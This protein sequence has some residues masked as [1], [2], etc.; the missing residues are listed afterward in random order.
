MRGFSDPHSIWTLSGVALRI[1]QRIGLH[2]DG[3]AFGLTAFETEMRRRIWFQL[4]LIDAT[5]AQFCG[6]APSPSI[7][8]A[9]TQPP[10]NAN[11]SDLDPRMTEPVPERSGATE[12]IFCLTRSEFGNWLRRWGKKYGNFDSPWAFLSS[13]SISLQEKDE[14]ID[15]FESLVEGKFLRFCDSSIPLHLTT[16]AMA[17]SAIHYARLTAHHPRQYRDSN[18]HIS[19]PEKDIIYENCLRM[20]EYAQFAQTNPSIQKF[21]WHMVNHMPWDAM[22]LML[23]EMRNR[24]DP[25]EKSKVWQIIGDIYS[26]YLRQ[27]TRTAHVP[28]LNALQNLIV[29]AWWTYIEECNNYNRVATPC[30]EIVSSLLEKASDYTEMQMRDGGSRTAE[31]GTSSQELPSQSIPSEDLGA[32]SEELDFLLTGSLDWNE[33]DKLMNQFQESLMDD[34]AAMPSS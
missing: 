10:T 5:S 33:W 34:I 31:L 3:S 9:D 8:T 4:V 25:E 7:A 16:T 22:I 13:S 32:S 19:Q 6:V 24:S 20:A 29:K 27:M 11:D 15:E 26:R 28:L 1:S 30:P 2:R 18:I 21:V 12:M 14:A 23:S 17:R